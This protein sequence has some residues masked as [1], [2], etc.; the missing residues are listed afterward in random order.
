MNAEA[1]IDPTVH[2]RR[3]VILGVLCLSLVLVVL[4]NST[5]NIALPTF[6]R[7]LDATTAQL[8]WIVDGYA[9]V[10]GGL[11]LTAGA[12][13]DRFGRKGALQ[14]GLA[15]FGLA[16]LAGTVSTQPEH[17]IAA[18]AAMGVGAALVM[19]ATLSILS[20]VFPASERGKAIG[21]WAAFAGVGGAIGPIVGGWLL[22]HFWWGSLFFMNVV[23]VVVALLLGIV[24]LPTSRDPHQT[25]LDPVGALLSIMALGG[26]L[27]GIIEGPERGWAD[28]VTVAAFVVA[29]VV[30]SAFV[31]WELRTEFPMLPMRLFRERGFSVG[32]SSITLAFFAMFGMFFLFTQYLQFVR[33]YSP[34]EAGVRT[35]P[36]AAGLMI[37]APNSD[38]LAQR[39]G[40]HRIVGSG[41]LVVSLG[42]V[43]L[44]FL[45]TSTPYW[46]IGFILFGLGLGMGGAMAPSTGS[47]MASMPLSKAGVGSA[48]NDTSREVG[49]AIGVAVLGS[50]LSAL[51]GSNFDAHAPAGAPPEVLE[52]ARESVGGALGIAARIGEPAAPLAEAARTAFTDSMGV[53]F[54]VG[55]AVVAVGGLVA[56]LKL[57]PVNHPPELDSA[58]AEPV[59]SDVGAS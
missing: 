48:V 6:Q 24:L 56:W 59:I 53:S 54:L 8:Q 20:N 40:A 17:L 2:H 18:R 30:G 32:S 21:I 51:Y 29:V 3:W 27:F 9:L 23:V 52:V 35:L 19:P 25:R 28:P 49:G 38:R 31:W 44:S 58:T 1:T 26:L 50:V 55:A 57:P 11:L 4:G 7:D 46:A 10:F 45:D 15:L 13:G 47:I 22:E 33:G 34:L 36:M 16:S 39:F 14:I 42:L 41:L 5:L 12:V 43:G 37:S